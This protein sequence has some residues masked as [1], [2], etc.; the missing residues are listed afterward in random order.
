MSRSR[1]WATGLSFFVGIAI[2]FAPIPD[3]WRWCITGI[4]ILG[5]IICLL[6]WALSP[7]KGTPITET[8]SQKI[9]SSEI[10][11]SNVASAGRD[12]HQHI[13]QPFP[14]DS[15]KIADFIYDGSSNN[16]K[17]GF[18][19]E[20]KTNKPRAEVHLHLR[21][22]NKGNGIAH[23]IASDVYGCWMHEEPPRACLIDHIEPIAGRVTPGEGRSIKLE[24]NR[25]AGIDGGHLTLHSRKDILVML[26]EITFSKLPAS[27]EVCRNEPIWLTW[28]PQINTALCDSKQSEVQIA[29]LAID[30]IRPLS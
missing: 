21:F 22:V 17:F 12:V 19:I 15:E 20:A 18:G 13:Y 6:G 28:T 2:Q 10:S 24:F 29:R 27:S 7:K 25:Y 11:G 5:I 4:A 26:F 30:N 16:I 23:N 9:R 1:K 8:A 14:S 3:I